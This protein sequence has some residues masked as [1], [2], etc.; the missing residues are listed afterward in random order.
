ME[1]KIYGGDVPMGL[2]MAL[3]QNRQALEKFSYM[4][5]SERKKLIDGTH[6]I[7]SSKEMEIYVQGIADGNMPLQG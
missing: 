4:N 1:N 7:K 5:D 6:N 2:G 3:V